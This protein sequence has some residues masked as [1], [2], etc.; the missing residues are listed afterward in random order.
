MVFFVAIPDPVVSLFSLVWPCQ[1]TISWKFT[2]VCKHFAIHK[3]NFAIVWAEFSSANTKLLHHAKLWKD[4]IMTTLV[5]MSW[6]D[7]LQ[8][9]DISLRNCVTKWIFICLKDYNNELLLFVHVLIVFT[10]F[11]F[12]VDEKIK[13]KVL[14]C[15]SE[16]TDYFWKSFQ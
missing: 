10:V 3:V 8:S 6:W 2:K 9:S 1:E 5:V 11:C 7:T 14:A 4:N 16:L 15:F 13:L 12:L